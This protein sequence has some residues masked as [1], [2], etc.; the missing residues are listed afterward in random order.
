MELRCYRNGDEEVVVGLWNAR[1]CGCYATGP[2]TTERFAADV[3]AKRYFE[4]EGLILGFERGR[5][6]AFVHA[7][8]KSADYI[9]PDYRLGTIA[10]VGMEA[11][12]AAAGEAAMA[13]AIRHLLRRGAKQVEAFTIDFPNTPFYNGLYGGE[14]AGMDEDHPG[15]L[16][17]MR[18]CHFKITNGAVIMVC[19]LNAEPEPLTVP[20][21]LQFRV[22]PWDSPLQGRTATECYGIPEP[23]RR[24]QLLDKAGK[25]M[26][27]I[28]FWNL[29]RHNQA[30]GRRM[31]VVTHVGTAPELRGGGASL[32]L[33]REVHRILMREGATLMGLGTGGGNGRAVRFYEKLGYRACKTAY[34]FHLDWRHYPK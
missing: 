25:E 2:L 28:S 20:D 21:G 13:E 15:G 18:R 31:A 32:A 23:M 33:Q 22:G 11:D 5:L 34:Y 4:P 10:M 29:E 27:G 14:K 30:T 1:I 8:F 7:G 16:E 9:Q 17:L 19:D 26:A 6:V 24:A 3:V 12:H